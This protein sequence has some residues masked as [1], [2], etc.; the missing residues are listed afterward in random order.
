MQFTY[1]GVKVKLRGISGKKLKDIQS[2]KLNKIF[3]DTCEL[4]MLQLVPFEVGHTPE[5]SSI[6]QLAPAYDVYLAA[7]LNEY[8]EVFTEPQG[9]QPHMEQFDHRIPLK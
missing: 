7:V 4:Y 5:L 6:E 8:S 3:Q 9:L 2:Q 1:K